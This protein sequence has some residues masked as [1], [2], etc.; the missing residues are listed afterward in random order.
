MHLSE[1]WFIVFSGIERVLFPSADGGSPSGGPP[2]Q[3]M[4]MRELERIR[5]EMAGF[6]PIDK[7]SSSGRS[8][9]GRSRY[10]SQNSNDC[11]DDEDYY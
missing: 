7:G 4:Y 10:L 6:K 8:S 2:N 1:I 11:F 9:H 5:G 3:Q